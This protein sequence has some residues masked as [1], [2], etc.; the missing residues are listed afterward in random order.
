MNSLAKIVLVAF[1]ASVVAEQTLLGLVSPSIKSNLPPS[2]KSALG[3]VKLDELKKV[4]EAVPELLQQ[5]DPEK[6][7]KIVKEKA[8]KLVELVQETAPKV[9]AAAQKVAQKI[10]A[11]LTPEAK[12]FLQ[13]VS[14]VVHTQ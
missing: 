9:K 14:F 8:P 1:V 6:A 7:L 2:A 13:Q 4:K 10:E 12:D 3:Q 5:T 11:N